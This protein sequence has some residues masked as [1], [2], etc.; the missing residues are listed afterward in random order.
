MAELEARKARLEAA[1]AR[2]ETPPPTLH[3]RMAEV[4]R[5]KAS[6]LAAALSAPEARTGAAEILR[7]LIEAVVLTP[8][9]E[10]YAIE[11]DTSIYL[12]SA[13]VC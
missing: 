13:A 12:A 5:A 10:G 8:E 4:Y 9:A 1:Q 11:L 2:E 3:P 7:G 6:D